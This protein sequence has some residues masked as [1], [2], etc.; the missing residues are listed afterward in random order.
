[1][2]KGLSDLQ[3]TIQS[4]GSSADAI[5]D[6]VQNYD[7]SFFGDWREKVAL[8]SQKL[9]SARKIGADTGVAYLAGSTIKSTAQKLF[10]KPQSEETQEGED[11]TPDEPVETP[12][13]TM[14]QEFPEDETAEPEEEELFQEP[15]TLSR[16]ITSAEGEVSDLAAIEGETVGST[17]GETLS[18]VGSAVL[19]TL[20]VASEALEMIIKYAFSKLNLHQLYA[21]ITIGN[22]QSISLFKKNNF[23]KVGEKKDW[24]FSEGKFKNELLFQLINE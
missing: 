13:S 5:N 2:S 3:N 16:T 1:M 22:L 20:G 18:G 14:E 10:G 12:T 4:Y 21:N 17:L 6:Y 9:E 23:V 24:I 19:G 7:S 11:E 15:A 8:K